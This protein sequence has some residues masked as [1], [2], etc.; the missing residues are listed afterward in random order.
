MYS[1]LQRDY[2]LFNAHKSHGFVAHSMPRHEPM[3]LFARGAKR[4]KAIQTKTI[5]GDP[6][7][8]WGK[9]LN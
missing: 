8:P 9:K 6:W 4:K 1:G 3:Q 7:Q 5:K 2:I